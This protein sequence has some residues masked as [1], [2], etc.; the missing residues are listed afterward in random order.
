MRALFDDML[1]DE[2]VSIM[3]LPAEEDSR[4]GDA[5]KDRSAR[6]GNRIGAQK[7]PC[8]DQQTSTPNSKSLQYCVKLLLDY[9]VSAFAD[10]MLMLL[11]HLNASGAYRAPAA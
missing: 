11:A 6:R 1:V 7:G 2:V 8:H 5:F 10:L 3:S 9:S 4:G